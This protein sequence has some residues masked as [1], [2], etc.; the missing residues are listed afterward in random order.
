MTR[1]SGAV[2]T[3]QV[4][5]DTEIEYDHSSDSGDDDSDID[6]EATTADLAPG[7]GVAELEQHN[8]Q[9]EEIEL[10]QTA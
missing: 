6:S 4:T 3:A 9:L 7:V 5:P 2:F 1:L 10:I 8:G